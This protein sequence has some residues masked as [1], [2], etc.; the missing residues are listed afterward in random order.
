MATLNHVCEWS[1]TGWKR[2]TV[3][4][5]IEEKQYGGIS[6]RRGLSLC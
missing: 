2:V 6:A 1:S 5:I 3:N 4:E